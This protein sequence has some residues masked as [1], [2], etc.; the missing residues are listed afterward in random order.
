MLTDLDRLAVL[1]EAARY[2]VITSGHPSRE[3]AEPTDSPLPVSYRA[4][5]AA[6]RHR[7]FVI[8]RSVAAAVRSLARIARWARE[9]YRQRQQARLTYDALRELDDRTLH[10]LGLDR[11]EI[12]SIA[13]EVSAETESSRVRAQLSS[14]AVSV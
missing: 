9:R 6:R 11:S 3:R 5:H 12:T 8:G 10:D 4:Y 13:A 1:T 2:G 7:G 14:H